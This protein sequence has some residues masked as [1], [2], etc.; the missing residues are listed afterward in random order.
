MKANLS[1]FLIILIEVDLENVFHSVRISHSECKCN[2]L[3]NKK[4][5]CQFLVQ[6]LGSTSN[7]KHFENKDDRHS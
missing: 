5:F 7:F 6:F 4:T 3:K 2:Y 1:C